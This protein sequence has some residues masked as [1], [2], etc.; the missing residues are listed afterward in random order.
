M[1][2]KIYREITSVGFKIQIQTHNG[3]SICFRSLCLISE[4][5]IKSHHQKNW[6]KSKSRNFPFEAWDF[7]GPLRPNWNYIL[8][9][10][11][12]L[13]LEGFCPAIVSNY[14]S[15]TWIAPWFTSYISHCLLQT[16]MM[17]KNQWSSKAARSISQKRDKNTHNFMWLKIYWSPKNAV[18]P[19][20]PFFFFF[21]WD[22]KNYNVY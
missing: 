13:P 18:K 20:K 15:K 6:T 7:V 1:L 3:G 17:L 5:S 21:T 11:I 8:P 9:S 2:W 22:S 12:K 16:I 10:D 14:V 19:C 4:F